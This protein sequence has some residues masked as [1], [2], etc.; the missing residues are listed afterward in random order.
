MKG[1]KP[2]NGCG[3]IQSI[4]DSI[5]RHVAESIF[6][7]LPFLEEGNRYVRALGRAIS[8][9]TNHDLLSGQQQ[10]LHPTGADVLMSHSSRRHEFPA[11]PTCVRKG[12][13]R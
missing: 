5:Q 11:Q 7:L 2:I 12:V 10:C 13:D 1:N 4:R 6:H 3:N 8:N 9:R